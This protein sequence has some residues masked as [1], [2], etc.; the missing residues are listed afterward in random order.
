M[1][2]NISQHEGGGLKQRFLPYIE[3]ML[4]LLQA[5]NVTAELFVEVLGCLANLYIPD[6]DYIG[7]RADSFAGHSSSKGAMNRALYVQAPRPFAHHLYALTL[8]LLHICT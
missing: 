8:Y 2:R 6:F 5:P 4:Q 1:V 7:A 3:P